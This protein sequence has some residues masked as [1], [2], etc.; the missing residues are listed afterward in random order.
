MLDSQTLNE[1]Y[2]VD[3]NNELMKTNDSDIKM[4]DKMSLS[5][6]NSLAMSFDD[7]N[8][9]KAIP[10][11]GLEL[12]IA[13]FYAKYLVLAIRDRLRHGRHFTLKNQNLAITFVSES[14]SGA[15]VS[16]REPFAILGYWLQILVNDDLLPTMLEQIEYLANPMSKIETPTNFEWPHD[17]LKIII[18]NLAIEQPF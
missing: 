5:H 4:F 10:L 11:E 17:N 12:S 2:L 7:S 13:P 3:E 14:V 9:A 6:N 15:A 18:D 1:Q 16:K 8:L